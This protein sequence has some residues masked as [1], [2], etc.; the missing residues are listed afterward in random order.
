MKN[1]FLF[2]SITFCLANWAIAQ[3]IDCARITTFGKVEICLPQIEGYQECYSD[4]LVKILADETEIEANAVLGFY[5]SNEIFEK[6]DSIG[7]VDFD[8]YF[9]IYGTKQIADYQ[10]DLE[11]LDQ[12]RDLTSGNFMSKNLESIQE[13][14]DELGFDLEIGV[15]VII[16]T[17]KLTSNSFTHLILVKIELKG[18][19]PMTRAVAL[20]GLL[21]NERLVWMAYYLYYD[22]EESIVMLQERS[23]QILA[24]ILDASE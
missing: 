11:A 24:E 6:K 8:D 13:S 22:G 18:L 4:S 23:D 2:L 21:I 9:K 16:K 1:I 12:I 20:N 10:A 17:Y 3:E 15:P 5:L 14:I 19:E 7:L